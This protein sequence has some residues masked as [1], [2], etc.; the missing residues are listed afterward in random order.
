VVVLL[1]ENRVIRHGAVLANLAAPV[2][3]VALPPV[4]RWALQRIM[5]CMFIRFI[6]NLLSGLPADILRATLIGFAAVGACNFTIVLSH[7]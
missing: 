5:Y 3:V 1:Y 7:F 6:V 4:A 2:E